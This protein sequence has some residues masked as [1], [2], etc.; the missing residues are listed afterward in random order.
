[1][2][3]LVLGSAQDLLITMRYAHPRAPARGY[4]ELVVE[5]AQQGAWSHH[6]MVPVQSTGQ[7]QR[8]LFR[9]LEEGVP[10]SPSGSA[11]G[12]VATD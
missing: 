2:R 11:R 8:L 6:L 9:Q 3:I 1:M 12:T 7:T 5:T 4:P 10:P